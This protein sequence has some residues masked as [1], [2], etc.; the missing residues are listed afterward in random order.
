VWLRIRFNVFLR[1]LSISQRF[2]KDRNNIVNSYCVWE[3][4]VAKRPAVGRVLDLVSGVRVRKSAAT[5]TR[6]V[7]SICIVGGRKDDSL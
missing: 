5:C 1:E 4:E 2:K 6:A 7:V 3:C